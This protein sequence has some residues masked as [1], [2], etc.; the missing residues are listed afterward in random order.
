M[1]CRG[2]EPSLK[3]Y[4]YNIIPIPR[5]RDHCRSRA[6]GDSQKICEFAMILLLLVLRSYTYQVS[7]T[8]LTKRDL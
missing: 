5:L 1:K 4:I 6:P 3:E 2:M 7:P 8:G